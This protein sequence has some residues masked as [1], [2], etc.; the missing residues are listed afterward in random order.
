MGAPALLFLETPWGSAMAD[1]EATSCGLNVFGCIL[2][3]R[4]L[5]NKK[6]KDY[7]KNG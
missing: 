3:T 2:I 6:N 5:D 1:K 7:H 4:P